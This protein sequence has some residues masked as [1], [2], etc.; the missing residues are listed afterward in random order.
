MILNS[1]YVFWIILNIVIS[2]VWVLPVSSE[3]SISASNSGIELL[4]GDQ[5]IEIC[6][7]KKTDLK[8]GF[9]PSENTIYHLDSL[10]LDD[11]ISIMPKPDSFSLTETSITSFLGRFNSLLLVAP[12][13]PDENCIS[14][15]VLKEHF[16]FVDCLDELNEQFLSS[17]SLVSL[18]RDSIDHPFSLTSRICDYAYGQMNTKKKNIPSLLKVDLPPS[19]IL[20][21]T[22]EIV[23]DKQFEDEPLE[24]SLNFLEVLFYKVPNIVSSILVTLV[25]FLLNRKQVTRV[26]SVKISYL[27]YVVFIVLFKLYWLGY[28]YETAIPYGIVLGFSILTVSPEDNAFVVLRFFYDISVLLCAAF[29]FQFLS[30]IAI[31]FMVLTPLFFIITVHKQKLVQN[32]ALIY[33]LLFLEMIYFLLRDI[34]IILIP[35]QNSSLYITVVSAILRNTTF[36]S[37]YLFVN[38]RPFVEISISILNAL[39]RRPINDVK[40]TNYVSLFRCIFSVLTYISVANIMSRSVITNASY[41]KLDWIRKLIA[42][43]YF[44]IVST[45]KPIYAMEFTFSA[46]RTVVINLFTLIVIYFYAFEILCALLIIASIGIFTLEA[47][48]LR[49]SLPVFHV[50]APDVLHISF[51]NLRVPVSDIKLS[52][53]STASILSAKGKSSALL[54]KDKLMTVSH[55][56]SERK[57]GSIRV[58][59][60]ET[61]IVNISEPLSLE[62][63]DTHDGIII[64]QMPEMVNEKIIKFRPPEI[65]DLIH[66]SSPTYDSL[67]FGTVVSKNDDKNTFCYKADGLPGDSGSP[68]FITNSIDDSSVCVGFHAGKTSDGLGLGYF[69]TEQTVKTSFKNLGSRSFDNIKKTQT[70]SHSAKEKTKKLSTKKPPDLNKKVVYLSPPGAHRAFTSYLHNKGFTSEVAENEFFLFFP[71]LMNLFNENGFDNDKFCKARHTSQNYLVIDETKYNKLKMDF[72]S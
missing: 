71:Q 68:I 4:I 44:S 54:I 55:A 6:S 33:W 70:G 41:D 7:V 53:D 25:I 36:N 19:K 47:I 14:F 57:G 42:K 8:Y 52:L 34:K 69:I 51:Q 72:C 21:E 5:K 29:S 15:F 43:S 27:I 49:F 38:V 2:F 9:S 62:V 40:L 61:K 32:N 63:G 13:T 1:N 46:S 35:F 48:E 28:S 60:K 30:Y 45:L 59:G 16:D 64:L 66:F 37:Y 56:L 50:E 3:T 67:C 10:T 23:R 26:V 22:V 20:I 18:K 12:P 11:M 17:C 39:S 65:E 24:N 31:M 58:N